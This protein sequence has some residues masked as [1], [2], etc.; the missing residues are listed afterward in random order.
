MGGYIQ[1]YTYIYI[2]IY[3][4]P[5]P[6][7]LKSNLPLLSQVFAQ[8][9]AQLSDI[10]SSSSW[11]ARRAR[12][13]SARARDQNAVLSK[14]EEL[15]CKLDRLIALSAH[16][17]CVEPPLVGLL[18]DKIMHPVDSHFFAAVIATI[19]ETM[20]VAN[21]TIKEIGIDL[22]P[23]MRQVNTRLDGLD[24]L[25]ARQT[26]ATANDGASAGTAVAAGTSV[27]DE[28]ECAQTDCRDPGE[29]CEADSVAL[30]GSSVLAE[31]DRACQATEAL[32]L[33]TGGGTNEDASLHEVT[34]FRKQV[35]DISRSLST[36]PVCDARYGVER[37][38]DH[39]RKSCSTKL[40]DKDIVGLECMLNIIKQEVASIVENSLDGCRT[41]PPRAVKLMSDDAV[42]LPAGDSKS[43]S[44][45]RPNHQM[46]VGIATRNLPEASLPLWRK[47]LMEL[48]F[49][50]E[51]M[52]NA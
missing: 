37:R 7:W 23:H 43:P 19:Q 24:S 42:K 22:Y 31:P 10:M 3:I 5:Y 17:P 25:V 39:F 13:I 8:K 20:Q 49:I 36:M 29:A 15:E 50:L 26:D 45:W 2:Y 46:Q 34:I 41:P 35:E 52:V 21:T 6:F 16:Q 38:I 40:C 44:S 4:Y 18:E 14:L 1:I 32:V 51:Q 12:I 9:S 48:T 47:I 27:L 33:P 30:I 28:S 11:P